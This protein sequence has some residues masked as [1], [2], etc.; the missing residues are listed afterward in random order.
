M[1][2]ATDARWHKP[3]HEHPE[4]KARSLLTIKKYSDWIIGQHRLHPG[5]QEDACPEANRTIME[6]L[7][8]YWCHLSERDAR[9]LGEEGH[10][11]CRTCRAHNMQLVLDP[12]KP[13]KPWAL[14]DWWR[15]WGCLN[16][17][18]GRP[19]RRLVKSISPDLVQNTFPSPRHVVWRS[20]G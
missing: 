15:T 7:N 4:Y 3:I 8:T 1:T 11:M 6:Y 9:L 13:G 14:T 2:P 20:N 19:A 10:E 5:Y 17:E 16:Y 18:F 12:S